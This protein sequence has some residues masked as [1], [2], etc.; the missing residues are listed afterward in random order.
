MYNVFKILIK[1]IAYLV[2]WSNT[3]ISNLR[4]LVTAV[5]FT[6]V[7]AINHLIV[8]KRFWCIERRYARCNC[9]FV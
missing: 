3:E 5:A 4:T 2:V 9:N 7:L 8:T 6:R 1:L